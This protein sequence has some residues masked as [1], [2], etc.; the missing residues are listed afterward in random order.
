M[1]EM[2]EARTRHTIP[3]ALLERFSKICALFSRSIYE[4]ANH[5]LLF[6]NAYMN[7]ILRITLTLKVIYFFQRQNRYVMLKYTEFISFH[8]TKG[9]LRITFA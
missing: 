6:L 5:F 2:G 7:V 3:V 8:H 9:G 4:K 1:R